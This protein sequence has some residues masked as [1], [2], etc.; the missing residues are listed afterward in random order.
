MVPHEHGDLKITWALK[1]ANRSQNSAVEEMRQKRF[2]RK[3]RQT[4]KVR[5]EL[6]EGYYLQLLVLKGSMSQGMWVALKTGE[7][8]N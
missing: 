3:I 7:A 4:R 2:F 1:S 8:S 6:W 5:F